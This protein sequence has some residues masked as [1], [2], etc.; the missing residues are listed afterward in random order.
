M[1]MSI[2]YSLLILSTIASAALDVAFP[3]NSQVPTVARVSEPYSFQFAGDTFSSSEETNLSY[4]LIG[5]PAWLNL[6]GATRTLYGT[7]RGSDQGPTDFGISANGGQ[8]FADMLCTLVIVD[9]GSPELQGNISQA[10][11]AAGALAGPTTLVLHPGDSFSIDFDTG[12]FQDNNG[13]VLTYYATSSDR[14][15]LPAWV[16]F[17]SAALSFSG[18]AP[19]LTSASQS[20]GIFLIAS[21]VVGF[22]GAVA[23]FTLQISDDKLAF[24]PQEEVLNITVGIPINFT[25]LSS[26]LRLNGVTAARKQILSATAVLPP[27]LSLDSQ[28]LALTGTPPPNFKTQGVNITVI[29]IF[30]DTA[31]KTLQLQ[32]GKFSLF[33]GHIGAINAT[34]G[35]PFSYTI[36]PSVFSQAG[37]D[38]S[39]QFTPDVPWLHFDSNTLTIS[40]QIPSS[41]RGAIIKGTLTAKSPT[42]SASEPQAFTIKINATPATAHSSLGS[43]PTSSPR[44]TSAPSQ[45]LPVPPPPTQTAAGAIGRTD[46]GNKKARIIAGAVVGACLLAV[47]VIALIILLIRWKRKRSQRSPEK[48]EISQPRLPSGA[49]EEIDAEQGLQDLE[50]AQAAQAAKRDPP[51]QIALDLPPPLRGDSRIDNR[52]SQASSL[53]VGEAAIRA[54]S[55]I[56]IWG[57]RPSAAHTPHDSY[58]AATQIARLSQLARLSPS[59]RASRFLSRDRR[60]R[61]S[62]GLGIDLGAPSSTTTATGRISKR[63]SNPL[64]LLRGDRSSV[65]S[66]LTRNTSL[67]STRASDFPHPPGG[68]GETRSS[69][70]LSI[71]ALSVTAADKRASIRLVDRSDSITDTRPLAEKRASYIRNRASSTEPSPLFAAGLRAST[72]KTSRTS[73]HLRRGDSMSAYSSTAGDERA[74]LSATA[75]Q[76]RGDSVA[77]TSYSASSSLEPPPRNPRRGNTP[78]R[79]DFFPGADDSARRRSKALKSIARADRAD[80]IVKQASKESF[81]TT[82]ESTTDED[83]EQALAHLQRELA[84]PRNQRTW[85]LP[86]EASPTPP[87]LT[88][89]SRRTPASAATTTTGAASASKSASASGSEN[90]RERARRKWAARLNRNSRGELAADGSAGSGSSLAVPTGYSSSPLA[91]TS[92]IMPL[93]DRTNLPSSPL[94]RWQESL[95]Q[96][97]GQGQGQGQGRDKGKGKGKGKQRTSTQEPLS[98]VSNDSLSGR[99]RTRERPRLVAA[100]GGK[101]PVSV[102]SVKRLS[103][104]RAVKDS[105]GDGDEEEEEAGEGAETEEEE[106]EEEWEDVSGESGESGGGGA[107]GR[108]Q[109]L[110][111]RVEMERERGKEGTPVS[112]RTFSG[113]AFI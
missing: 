94:G 2:P 107:K 75:R 37:L 56:P 27:W 41:S 48:M 105:G 6:D 7:P 93:G 38:I 45:P 18:R 42:L 4:N 9:F 44:S 31:V 77:T 12:L 70:H 10:L 95:G 85:V 43:A 54:D 74:Y 29:D 72:S 104:F 98:L 39:V 89:L 111:E 101:R 1:N 81:S 53:G 40:G 36:N 32:S 47:L 62:V 90:D 34:A 21:D 22:A 84:L 65:G 100:M 64:S 16:K 96:G 5:A 52:I 109:E 3:F 55:N 59:K 8:G 79:S 78:E 67:L 92:V 80:R 108:V 60:S 30:G 46:N 106:E 88:P 25:Q 110:V 82:E 35:K 14:T 69:A 102:E 11:S 73:S 28:T 51:P 23:S 33:N 71:P 91:A 97:R 57:R 113:R 76:R 58:S 24:V 13:H 20:F 86:G 19:A 49:Y 50:K 15:P 26:E 103:S 61:Q 87:P 99:D 68:G 66:L 17:N 83:D 112:T 63:R